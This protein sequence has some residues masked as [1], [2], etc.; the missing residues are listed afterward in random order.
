MA[1]LNKLLAFFYQGKCN[2]VD[3]GEVHL[4]EYGI[5]HIDLSIT[6]GITIVLFTIIC[7]FARHIVK[8]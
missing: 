5:G 1:L 8:Y 2:P 7:G 4:S 6:S 3:K